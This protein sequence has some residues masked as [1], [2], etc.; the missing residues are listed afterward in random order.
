MIDTNVIPMK[1]SIVEIIFIKLKVSNP[2]DLLKIKVNIVDV[3]DNIVEIETEVNFKL[4]FI[5]KFDKFQK[6][7]IK[8]SCL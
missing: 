7:I 3:D 4:K 2:K 8:L 1:E 5:N 6:I